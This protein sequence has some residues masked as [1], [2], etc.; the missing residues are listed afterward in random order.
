MS[1]IYFTHCVSPSIS[2][3][4]HFRQAFQSTY[5]AHTEMLHVGSNWLSHICACIWNTSLMSSSLLL[6]QCHVCIV[7]LIFMVFK[8]TGW[9]PSSYCSAGQPIWKNSYVYIYIYIYTIFL[10]E[11]QQNRSHRIINLSPSCYA[12][13]KFPKTRKKLTGLLQII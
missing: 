7:R 10:K 4:Y 13:L 2:I 11:K 3:M 1:C 6:Q 12:Y 5:S 9:W 8:M